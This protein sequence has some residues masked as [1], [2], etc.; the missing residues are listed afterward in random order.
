MTPQQKEQLIAM[1]Q[2]LDPVPA[3]AP[4]NSLYF[5]QTGSNSNPGTLASP[6]QNLQGVNLNNLPPTVLR[7]KGGETWNFT[8]TI[9]LM[10][11]N[12]NASNPLVLE[13]YGSG[14]AILKWTGPASGP[15]FEWG[16]WQDPRLWSGYTFRNLTLDG[17]NGATRWG[18][19]AR[20]VTDSI[21]IENCTI[22]GFQIGING[23]GN[24][25][26]SGVAVR[27]CLITRNTD[28]GCLGCF[29]NSLFEN[30]TISENN[31]GGSAFSHGTYFSSCNNLTLKGNKYIRN[32]VVDGINSGGNMTFHGKMD[33]LLI[34][35]NWIEQDRSAAWLMSITQGYSS[36]EGFTNCVVRGNTL[37][38]GGN[39]AI[40][41]QSAPGIVIE[42]NT[43]INRQG[44]RQTAIS[45][46]NSDY[47]DGDLPD[48]N[49]VV[50]NNKIYQL[51][52]ST[53]NPV[54]FLNSPGSVDSN[55]Q[56]FNTEP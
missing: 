26:V 6:K 4:V 8:S 38:N 15:A 13:S 33:S 9:R 45:V 17:S 51:N 25:G 16:E 10:N 43:I 36:A 14:Q 24:Q 3:P 18:I 37:I 31:F 54:S 19:W 55:N 40:V 2:A 11:P 53:G 1:V 5:S 32:S 39:A 52:G 41:A 20:G 30:N 29:N 47:P 27:N 12:V 42:N 46:G 7:F 22:T 48:G 44:T 21:L 56:V 50:R 35:G 23:Q 49:A 28:M 34:E